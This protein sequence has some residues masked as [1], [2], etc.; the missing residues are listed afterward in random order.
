MSGIYS[1]DPFIKPKFTF[2]VWVVL[3]GFATIIMAIFLSGYM[4]RWSKIFMRG[5]PGAEC[6]EKADCIEGLN[7]KSDN[8]CGC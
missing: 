3:M 8:T 6:K 7:C 5:F 4:F 2:N 1:S